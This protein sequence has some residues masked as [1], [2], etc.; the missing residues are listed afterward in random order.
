MQTITFNDQLF[1]SADELKPHYKDYFKG[2]R[3]V[4]EII[5]KKGIP[6]LE[7][8]VVKKVK[9]ELVVCDNMKYSRAKILLKK[10]FCESNII[11]PPAPKKKVFK[12]T[13]EQEVEEE[14][15]ELIAPEILDLEEEEC[16]KD[17]EGNILQIEVRGERDRKKIFFKMADISKEFNAPNLRIVLLN[18]EKFQKN[19]HYKNFTCNLGVTKGYT[20]TASKKSF[21]FLTYKGLLRF[22]FVSRN[23]CAEAFQDWAEEKLFTMQ[24]GKQEQKEELA[25]EVL[26]VNIRDLR[27]IFRKH[28]NNLPC[29]YLIKLGKVSD[30][31]RTFKIPDSYSDDCILYKYG[32]TED[33]QTRLG[34]HSRKFDKLDDVQIDLQFFHFIDPKFT[35]KAENKLKNLFEAFEK[36]FSYSTEKEFI[37]LNNK[38][39]KHA[40]S[41]FK[42]IGEKYAGISEELQKKID[43]LK[44]AHKLEMVE[45]E[46]RH[47]L[48]KLKLENKGFFVRKRE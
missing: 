21:I 28:A 16:F 44:S 39:M 1:Y 38:E 31:R 15:E 47:N 46:N 29:I 4:K 18:K 37:I 23:P 2:V 41:M 20:K 32:F 25:A 19:I 40:K 17:S 35:S 13:I 14:E 27:A 34:Q 26:N 12:T 30:I 7:Y 3:T 6:S 8:V 33:L 10:D 36:G 5:D 48:E 43:E 45:M 9:D 24:M 11:N 22:L 42:M